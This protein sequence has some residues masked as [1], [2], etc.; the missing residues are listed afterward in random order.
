M[1]SFTVQWLPM[2]YLCSIRL[3]EG[4]S[5]SFLFYKSGLIIFRVCFHSFL[6]AG[7]ELLLS[8]Y[9]RGSLV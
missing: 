2:V 7:S 3:A 5:F 6:R 4:V 9:V 8:Q 1:W